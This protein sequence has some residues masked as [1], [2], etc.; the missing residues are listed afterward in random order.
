MIKGWRVGRVAVYTSDVIA[1]I[2]TGKQYNSFVWEHFSIVSR[3]YEV[4]M[5][6]DC[7]CVRAESRRAITLNHFFS[8]V[9]WVDA[10]V[11]K[12]MFRK[13]NTFT[14]D[15]HNLFEAKSFNGCFYV[16]LVVR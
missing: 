2:L 5:E 15:Y 1:F 9:M 7:K 6:N 8:D 13:R 14:P 16:P 10:G 4:K 3:A 12:Y 11:F